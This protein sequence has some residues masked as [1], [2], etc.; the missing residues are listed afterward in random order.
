MV[1]KKVFFGLLLVFLQNSF[2]ANG[3]NAVWFFVPGTPPSGRRTP[4]RDR[5][6]DYISD[7]YLGT[8]QWE[9]DFF[10]KLVTFADMRP[11]CSVSEEALNNIFTIMV[12]EVFVVKDFLDRSFERRLTVSPSLGMSSEKDTLSWVCDTAKRYKVC[13]KTYKRYFC[14]MDQF[15]VFLYVN[16][17]FNDIMYIREEILTATQELERLSSGIDKI[18]L[19]WEDDQLVDRVGQMHID[20][21]Y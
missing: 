18:L 2:T 7:L 11:G 3:V 12:H 4:V 5:N 14:H 9:K 21:N 17:Q 13:M 6:G 19:E 16:I 1:N 15:G 8:D 20:D 10:E